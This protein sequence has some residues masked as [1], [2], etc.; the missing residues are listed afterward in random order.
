VKSVLNDGKRGIGLP[1]KAVAVKDG[2]DFDLVF[3][4]VGEW[5]PFSVVG[6]GE[7][8]TVVVTASVEIVTSTGESASAFDFDFFFLGFLTAVATVSLPLPFDFSIGCTVVEV[9]L[10]NSTRISSDSSYQERK[11][12][13]MRVSTSLICS[14]SSSYIIARITQI[15]FFDL[16]FEGVNCV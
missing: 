6:V 4:L 7:V 16:F 8:A 1:A 11:R 9:A 14:L 3:F 10:D 13:Q 15:N 12:Q 2:F 5:L